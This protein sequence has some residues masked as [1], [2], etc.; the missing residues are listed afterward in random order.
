PGAVVDDAIID[1]EN[2]LRR[3]REAR[4]A[5]DGTSTAKI[6]LEAS[7]EVRSPIVYATMI[8]VAAA[9]PVFLLHGLTAAFFRPLALAYTLA[10][11]ASMAVALT[12]TPALTL[13][14]LRKAALK[15]LQSPIVRW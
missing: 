11:L 7:L 14:F 1:V 13:L 3:L 8:I 9:V 5:G 15:R 2:I 12:G 4:A 6:I 10:I